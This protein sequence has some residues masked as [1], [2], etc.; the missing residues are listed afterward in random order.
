[1]EHIPRFALGTWKSPN[2]QVVTDSVRYAIE[3]AG[4]RHID[5][6]KCYGNEAFVGKALNDVLSRHVVERKDL[7]VT[8]KL[9]NTDHHPEHVEEACRKTL[10]DLQLDYLDLYIIHWPVSFQ[11]GGELFPKDENGDL[12]IDTSA[13]I[14]DTWKALEQLVEK[15]LVRHIGVSNFTIEL[16]EKVLHYEDIKI[17]PYVDQVECHLYQ[18]QQALR[19][20]CNKRGII[21][22]GYSILGTADSARPCDPV[23]LKDEVLNEIANECGKSAAQVELQFLYQ[24]DQNLVIIAK[25]VTPSRI[26]ENNERTFTLTDEQIERLKARN[27]C[28][29]YCDSHIFLENY[30]FWRSLVN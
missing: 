10:K 2:D 9:W 24:L 8:S 11:H 21:V 20:F 16:L 5:C 14:H 4:Y 17:K 30:S 18:Q 27:R 15:K 1:M 28:Y 25:S 13:N 19:E 3:E 26:K 29:R 6:A 23:L 12:L 22:E 7:W